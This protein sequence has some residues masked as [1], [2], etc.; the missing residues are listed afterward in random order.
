ME[1]EAK[2]RKTKGIRWSKLNAQDDRADTKDNTT[3]KIIKNGKGFQVTAPLRF[4]LA[5][6]LNLFRYL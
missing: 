6:C 3:S 2:I 5:F 4:L 1:I